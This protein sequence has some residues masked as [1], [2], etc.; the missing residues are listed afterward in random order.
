MQLARRFLPGL[1]TVLIVAPAG[2]IDFHI[3]PG[4]RD[5]N[6][7]TAALP[8]RTIGEAA[9]VATPGTNIHVAPGLYTEILETS[10]S[11]T[12][13]APITYVSTVH[14]GAKIRTEGPDDHWSWINRGNHVVIAGFD[15]SGNG[16]GGIDNF[17]TNVRIVRNRV[18]NI[19]A[20][21][22]TSNG[23]AGIAASNYTN[24]NVFIGR[25]LVHDIGE[26]PEPCS[27]VHGI[28]FQH[29]GGRIVNNIVY[30]VT[31]WGIHWWHAPLRITIANN[32]A[33]NNMNGGIG[34]G[35][36]DSPYFGDP[37]KPAD[38]ITVMNNIVYDNAD[39]G[40]EE[41]GLSGSNNLFLNNISIENGRDWVLQEQSSHS[42]TA[43]APPGFVRYDPDGNGDYRLR[44]D[45][46]AI[47][48]GTARG[49]PIIDYDGV[50]RPQGRGVDIG[51]FEFV[52]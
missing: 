1:L 9:Q 32:L 7:G 19:P 39:T 47:D 16:A 44:A 21:G 6:P 33:F 26:F 15:V 41:T 17:G 48:R 20:L 18:H 38:H 30:R 27:R 11:G 46:P 40:I 34:G 50:S 13:A 42:G 35:A 22:C 3:A 4:G 29:E 23:G 31:G 51:P 14:W 43:E 5:G 12:A 45:S 2:A 37:S 28:Y 10:E 36:G 8:F 24:T 49:A 52:P 25:N